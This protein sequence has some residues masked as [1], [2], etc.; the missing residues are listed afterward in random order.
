MKNLFFITLL[1]FVSGC[2]T[3]PVYQLSDTALITE[4][5]KV[6]GR[7]RQLEAEK[8][9]SSKNNFEFWHTPSGPV[10]RYNPTW[11]TDVISD[12]LKDLEL[13]QLYKRRGEIIS[14]MY[15]RG[16]TSNAR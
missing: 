1:F 6:E 13:Q 4:Y 9:Q 3:I 16:I 10:Y 12:S 5:H 15:R 7:I 8:Y 2:A 11:Q 14:E